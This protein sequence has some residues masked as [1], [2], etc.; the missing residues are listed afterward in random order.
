MLHIP[1]FI[2]ATASVLSLAALTWDRYIAIT[3]PLQYRTMLSPM[4]TAYLTG[5]IWLV[6]IIIPPVIYIHVG[7][8]HYSSIL[9]FLI[10][11]FSYVRIFQRFRGQIREWD[12]LN[13]T[14]DESQQQRS[15]VRWETKVTKTLLLMLVLFLACY[16]PACV[17]S[18]L[19]NFCESCSCS[20][21]QFIRDF[22]F[23]FVM[24]SSGLNPILYAWRLEPYR[25]AFK[26][27]LKCSFSRSS[28]EL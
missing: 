28:Y 23:L 25:E 16:A 20:S 24:L 3:S 19:M 11:I 2:S 10:L 7:Y 21:I 14:T 4:R 9:T 12:R 17:L 15:L 22:H 6:S 18:Y 26:K 27:I 1:Y 5:L 13:E 8:I